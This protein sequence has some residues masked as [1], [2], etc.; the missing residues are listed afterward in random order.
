MRLLGLSMPLFV[1][2][3]RPELEPKR[4]RG[5]QETLSLEQLR[6]F[7]FMKRLKDD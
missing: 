4:Q 1:E 3:M 6:P 7:V 5:E 2:P